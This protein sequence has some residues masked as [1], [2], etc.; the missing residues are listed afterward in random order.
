MLTQ[1]Y[2]RTKILIYSF[3]VPQIFRV[4]SI[5]QSLN[6]QKIYKT[7][8]SIHAVAI[9]SANRVTCRCSK[10]KIRNDKKR[11][12]IFV[13]RSCYFLDLISGSDFM[14]LY[15]SIVR[16]TKGTVKINYRFE[17]I[18]WFFSAS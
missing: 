14:I 11:C 12:E 3:R 1:F 10:S 16:D 9:A 17:F 7:V 6:K 8:H 2:H 13:A 5:V 4:C 15:S 18:V